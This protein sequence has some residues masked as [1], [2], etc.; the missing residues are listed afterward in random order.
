VALTVNLSSQPPSGPIF[1]FETNQLWLNL[2]HFLYLLGR[3]ERNCATFRIHGSSSD[4]VG[5]DGVADKVLAFRPVRP[6]R[7]CDFPMMN[8]LMVAGLLVSSVALVIIGIRT[9]RNRPH[10]HSHSSTGQL[11]TVSQQW[12]TTHRAEK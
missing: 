8:L 5:R 9:F 2:H 6:Y 7:V 1:L 3:V 10:L 11:G 12:L 4:S